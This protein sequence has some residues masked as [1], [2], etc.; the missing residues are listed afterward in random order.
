MPTRPP[1]IRA[2][3]TTTPSTQERLSPHR[4]GYTAKWQKIRQRVFIRDQGQ[5]RNCRRVLGKPG[6]AHADHIQP[7]AAGGTDAM[8]NLQLLC[9][10]CHGAKTR[11]EQ[12]AGLLRRARN[13]G[14]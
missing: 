3:R 4:R 11:A 13:A 9:D 10:R 2:K 7:K 6:E 5:C 8:S 14:E 12:R 1:I